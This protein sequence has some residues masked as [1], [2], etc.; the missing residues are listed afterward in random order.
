LTFFVVTD[1]KKR[2]ETGEEK[3]VVYSP[4]RLLGCHRRAVLEAS[5][6]FYTDIDDSYPLTRGN[7]VHA[8]MEGAAYP[9]A[10]GVMRE[11]RIW[12]DVETKHG[13][14]KFGGKPDVVVFKGRD[15][16]G[17]LLAKVVDYKS[18]V[19]VTH[20]LVAAQDDHVA[21]VNMYAW[22]VSQ[23]YSAEYGAPVVVDEL[24]VM[25]CGLNK[26]RRF[27]SAGTL[28]T[29]GKMLTRSPKTYAT[30]TLAAIPLWPLEKTALAVRR[31]LT[32]L[33]SPRNGLP[34]RLPE[35]KQWMCNSCPVNKV[36]WAK[37]ND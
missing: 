13:V 25:Y 19:E 17:R 34:E 36:C 20:D 6:D 9:Y 18:K 8:M 32:R 11:R 29:R 5:T 15:E 26:P 37:E 1:T 35:E 22:L 2:R 4:T 3:E 16:D 30:L 10:I 33:L 23:V 7:M 28:E 14:A 31:R 24:E 27:T 12:V 21:Q